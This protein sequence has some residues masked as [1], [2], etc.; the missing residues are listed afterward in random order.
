MTD[1]TSTWDQLAAHMAEIATLSGAR[2]AI[3]WDQQVM[4][5]PKAA[6]GRG[7]Q[8][9]L[10]TQL[11]HDRFV[12][13]QVGAWLDAL[14]GDASLDAVQ[15]GAV[16]NLQ[17]AYAREVR[18]P[19][20]LVGQLA[21]AQ[22]RGFEQ[23]VQAKQARD[24]SAF[25]PVL[26]ELLA[27]SI[28]RA[29]AIAPGEHP[30]QVWLDEFDPGTNIAGLTQM[31]A[32]LREGLVALLDAIGDRQV[33]GLDGDVPV[34][35]QLALHRHVAEAL[36]YD[37]GA[38]RL[39]QSAHPFTIGVGP[40]DV[41][42]TTRVEPGDLL[43][44][45]GGTIHETGHALYEQGLPDRFFGMGVDDAAS[46][47]LHESQSRFWENGIGRS[48]AFCAWLAPKLGEQCDVS[49]DAESLYRAANR[50]RRGLI[51]VNADEVTYNLHII[52]RFEL[53]L[54]LCEGRLAVDDLPAAWDDT[55]ER[56]LGVRPAHAGEG[57]L[58]D[59][60]WSGAAFGYFPSY[61]LGNLYAASY[62]AVLVRDQPALWQRVQA[63]DF[64]EVLG[65]LRARIHQRGHEVDAPE[66]V[67]DAV[68]DRDHVADLLDDLWAR[69]GGV[70]GVSR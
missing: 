40:G 58:Q 17:R 63:G 29:N 15:R 48:R 32:R 42:I 31:F 13:P 39:D 70:Y 14:A 52:A 34:E 30:Y 27:L 10:L 24:F 64:G 35:R 21:E 53:E 62:R 56:L 22:T 51:R 67:R 23:W 8:V 2:A 4:M 6:A 38:G 18:V 7:A 68:G 50:V 55:Y 57:V 66:I 47:G 44:G 1:S 37:F 69:Y 11:A 60:H 36:G 65:W 33:D 9:A 41:R 43:A 49:V 61:T 19:R 46:L 25:A 26:R 20:A 5:P 45:L 3:T 12:D 59:V 54:A 16:R 28:A